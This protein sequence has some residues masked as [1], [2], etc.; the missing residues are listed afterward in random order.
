MERD[1]LKM[2][3][4]QNQK[5]FEVLEESNKEQTKSLATIAA[6]TEHLPKL[7]ERIESLENSRSRMKGYLAGVAGIGPLFDIA[8]RVFK[9]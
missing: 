2:L 6:N 8:L 1:Y 4:D 7:V 3:H 5:R 9:V